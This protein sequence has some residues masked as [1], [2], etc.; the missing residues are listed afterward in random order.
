[1]RL[2]SMLG[3]EDD[4][5]AGEVFWRPRRGAGFPMWGSDGGGGVGTLGVV[6]VEGVR[7]YHHD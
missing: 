4:R 1:M 5:S 3:F 7:L 2:Q 6:W